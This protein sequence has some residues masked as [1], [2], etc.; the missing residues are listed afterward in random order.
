MFRIMLS[1][2][3]G[4]ISSIGIMGLLERARL[5]GFPRTGLE[6]ALDNMV[7]DGVW[8]MTEEEKKC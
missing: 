4:I 2:S 7:M 5:L 1:S 3:I 6:D 8:N